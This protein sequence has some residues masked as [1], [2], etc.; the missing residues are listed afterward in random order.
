MPADFLG[1]GAVDLALEYHHRLADGDVARRVVVGEEVAGPGVGA[2][3]GVGVAG[4]GLAEGWKEADLPGLVR[5]GWSE[6]RGLV[7]S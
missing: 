3:R 5:L 7:A 4:A 1:G 2:G 6:G